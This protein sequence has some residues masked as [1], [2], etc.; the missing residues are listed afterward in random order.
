MHGPYGVYQ[1]AAE[2]QSL[3]ETHGA[4]GDADFLGESFVAA[5]SGA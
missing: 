5:Y 4:V 1:L 2:G 3:L